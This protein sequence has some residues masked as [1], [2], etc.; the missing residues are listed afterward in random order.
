MVLF[1][2]HDCVLPA[3]NM[4]N[5]QLSVGWN[6]NKYNPYNDCIEGMNEVYLLIHSFASDL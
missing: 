3:V 6:I 4:S 1:C 5:P 2:T